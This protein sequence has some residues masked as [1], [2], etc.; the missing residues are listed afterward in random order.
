LPAL[1]DEITEIKPVVSEIDHP[2][3]KSSFFNRRPNP[4]GMLNVMT[5]LAKKVKGSLD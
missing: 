2:A 4:E 3:F 5:R 1:L